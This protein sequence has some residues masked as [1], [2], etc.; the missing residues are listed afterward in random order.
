MKIWR[1][2]FDK[3]KRGKQMQNN[4][5]ERHNNKDDKLRRGG[6]GGKTNVMMMSADLS[7]TLSSLSLHLLFIHKCLLWW[8]N[9]GEQT[10]EQLNLSSA[11]QQTV[12]RQQDGIFMPLSVGRFW[13]LWS[14]NRYVEGEG[15]WM[16]CNDLQM[17]IRFLWWL[18]CDTQ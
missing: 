17:P 16:K 14:M 5:R 13:C 11:P 15:E 4:W 7:P 1:Q 10:R 6:S 3:D 2:R 8:S 9:K 12:V 18:V